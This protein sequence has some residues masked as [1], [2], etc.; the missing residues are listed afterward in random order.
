[1]LRKNNRVI[2]GIP[3]IFLISL[4]IIQ[5][6]NTKHTKEIIGILTKNNKDLLVCLVRIIGLYQVDKVKPWYP[7]SGLPGVTLVSFVL[8]LGNQLG[9]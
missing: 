1:M 9:Y 3:G 6:I 4:L 2:Q 7:Y 5:G 8:I